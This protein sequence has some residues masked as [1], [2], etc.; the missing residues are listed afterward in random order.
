MSSSPVIY[1]LDFDGVICDSVV[2][3]SETGIVAAKS[4]WPDLQFELDASGRPAQWLLDAMRAVRPVIET[5]FENVLLGRLLSEVIQTTVQ[6]NFVDLVLEDWVG[7]RD[8]VMEEWGESK[9]RLVEVFGA[10]RDLWIEKD[11]DAWINA[12]RMY[13]VT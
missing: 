3:S 5:G 8:D 7:L 9:E 11:I 12:N 10:S 4:L 13:V 2:E 6:N 1:A